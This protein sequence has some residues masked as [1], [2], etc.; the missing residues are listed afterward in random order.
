MFVFKTRSIEDV[1]NEL[2]ELAKSESR[3]YLLYCSKN[4]AKII[5]EESAK[6]N[7][8]N[9]NYVWIV[10]ESIVGSDI[11]THAPSQFPA[12]MLGIHFNTTHERLL[13]EIERAVNIFG[14]GL[15]SFASNQQHSHR[16]LSPDL[17]CN[18]TTDRRWLVGEI[19]YK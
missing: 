4:H 19:L 7:L 2:R 18:E 1:K 14:N 9:R 12:G 15:D 17:R 13:D 6:L 11:S 8:T 16:S 10:S 3:V 5:L